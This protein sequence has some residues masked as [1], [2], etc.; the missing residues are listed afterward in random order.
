MEIKLVKW[1]DFKNISWLE[2]SS[3]VTYLKKKNIR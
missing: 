3:E 1:M 2:F